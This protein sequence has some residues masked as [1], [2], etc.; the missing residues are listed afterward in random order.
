MDNLRSYP[1][2]PKL[3]IP[4]QIR[5][6]FDSLTEDSIEFRAAANGAVEPSK[7]PIRSR[8]LGRIRDSE[9]FEHIFASIVAASAARALGRVKSSSS[10][11]LKEFVQ[12][13]DKGVLELET[14]RSSILELLSQDMRFATLVLEKIGQDKEWHDVF[15][16]YFKTWKDRI[17]ACFEKV[18]SNEHPVS[19]TVV[20]VVLSGTGLLA[21]YNIALKIAPEL[22]KDYLAIHIPVT[23]GSAEA[24]VKVNVD[25]GVNGP[26]KPIPVNLA[27]PDPLDL[28]LRP[29]GPVR[30]DLVTSLTAA[31]FSSGEKSGHLA[32]GKPTGEPDGIP[33]NVVAVPKSID[34]FT[35]ETKAYRAEVDSL[36]ARLDGMDSLARAVNAQL[37]NFQAGTSITV[38]ENESGT[39]YLQWFDEKLQP[40][41]CEVQTMVDKVGNTMSSVRFVPQNCSATFQPPDPAQAAKPVQLEVNQP[42]KLLGLPFHVTAAVVERRW[43][44]RSQIE[45]RFQQDAAP[46]NTGGPDATMAKY[47]P[48][49]PGTH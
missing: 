20:A 34:N 40:T 7:R 24:K 30:V 33:V 43:L 18:S 8:V 37:S 11:V 49:A 15:D 29:T 14:L 26:T 38:A 9:T 44:G 48:P 46:L 41:S 2:D 3:G 25:L 12:A 32:N 4:S 13:S 39:V 17:H 23:A 28:T 45:F 22:T 47:T 36:K 6:F 1:V 16:G 35:A 27:P 10:E 31:G 5:P 42:K 19:R 21:S